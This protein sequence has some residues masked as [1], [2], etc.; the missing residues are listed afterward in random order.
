MLWLLERAQDRDLFKR[1]GPKLAYSLQRM[2]FGDMLPLPQGRL[3]CAPSVWHLA[4]VEVCRKRT[5]PWLVQKSWPKAKLAYSLQRMSFGDMLPLPQG[6]LQCVPSVWRL[7]TVEVCRKRTRPWLVQKS[8]PKAKL[9]YSL[10][11]MSFGDMLPLP[12]KRLQCVPSV[13]RLATVEVCRKRT[14]PW[15][16]QKSWP[17][18]K[19]AYSL[20]RMSF[21]DRLPL[22]QGR[23]QCAP[24]V[25]RLATVEVCRNWHACLW[26]LRTCVL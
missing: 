20:Q 13:W 18:A 12:Q 7:A 3:Q 21:G 17:K 15:L 24:S 22:P 26:R 8:W 9:A 14:R 23:L 2:S 4:T 16:V 25:W 10:Q 5:R 6:R 1:A 19:R 11:R